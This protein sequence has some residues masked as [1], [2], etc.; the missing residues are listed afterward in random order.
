MFLVPNRR[1][2]AKALNFNSM[3]PAA[4]SKYVLVIV[5]VTSTEI[6]LDQFSPSSF[7]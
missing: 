6:L 4:I 7:E 2:Q 3:T 1:F 5:V